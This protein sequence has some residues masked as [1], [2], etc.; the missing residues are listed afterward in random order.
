M[1]LRKNANKDL[2]TPLLETTVKLNDSDNDDVGNSTVIDGRCKLVN[3]TYFCGL[4]LGAIIQSCSIYAV[5]FALPNAAE[6]DD[7]LINNFPVLIG[8]YCFS[9]Y[10]VVAA[11]LIPPFVVTMVQKYKRKQYANIRGKL[12]GYFEC[13]RFQVGMFFGSLILLS[14]VNFHALAKTAPLCLLLTYY[15]VC[16][17][18]S[19]VALCVL[20][21][22]INQICANVSS[23]EIIVSYD[24]EDGEDYCDEDE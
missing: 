24:K 21:I 10:W 19:F 13:A 14:V 23:V 11:L 7:A 2:E 8:L 12:E 4:F 3:K 5:G 16:V 17:V 20:Q 6:S 9:R 15:F 18:V 22:F 1:N